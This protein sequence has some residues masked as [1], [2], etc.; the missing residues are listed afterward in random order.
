MTLP[1]RQRQYS[2]F[3][4]LELLV[5]VALIG[6]MLSVIVASVGDGGRQKQMENE[7]RRLVA[8]IKLARDEAVLMSQ[9]LAL[10]VGDSHYD[11]QHFGEK[12]WEPLPDEKIL[13]QHDLKDGLEIE[14]EMEDFVFTPK[15]KKPKDDD[16]AEP[17]DDTAVR[18]YFLSSGELQ[19]FTLYIREA[20]V[21]DSVRFK[22]EADHN[23]DVS[24]HG[25]LNEVDL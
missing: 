16:K 4:L 1:A 11:F 8:V 20:D 17:D 9:E 6:V 21:Y 10:V 25:P 23:G 2:G 13:R 22:V 15:R 12:G 5:V 19:A 18:I 14:L 7:A 24:W 3:T